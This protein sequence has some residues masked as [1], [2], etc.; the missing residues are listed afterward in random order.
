MCFVESVYVNELTK[1]GYTTGFY[2]T[3]SG[4]AVVYRSKNQ[5]IN[6]LSY[7]ETK[8]I[9]YVTAANTDRLLRYMLRELGFPQEYPTPIYEDNDPIIGIVNF[10]MPTERTRHISVQLFVIEGWKEDGDVIM[11]HIHGIISPVDDLT[12]P[13]GW[14]LYSRHA[15]YLM[16]HYNISFRSSRNF[17]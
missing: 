10:S 1:R 11:H 15:R 5:L 7:T 14:V 8:I 9:F 16:R 2:Y 3:F 12:K 13:L 4:V 17:Y 6:A